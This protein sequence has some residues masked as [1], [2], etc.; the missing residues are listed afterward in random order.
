MDTVISTACFAPAP[1]EIKEKEIIII[2]ILDDDMS[3]VNF[4]RKYSWLLLRALQDL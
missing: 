3:P 2:F 1:D 4:C